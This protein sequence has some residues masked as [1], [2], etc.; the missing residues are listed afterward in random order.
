L[1][2]LN[3][4]ATNWAAFLAP[5]SPNTATYQLTAAS[6][7]AAYMEASYRSAYA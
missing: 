3:S 7:T 1:S 6:A 4:A 2:M 5:P